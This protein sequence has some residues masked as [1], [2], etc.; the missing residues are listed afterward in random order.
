MQPRR[1]TVP[2]VKR[3]H[4]GMQTRRSTVRYREDLHYTLQQGGAQCSPAKEGC[5][6]DAP[7]ARTCIRLRYNRYFCR[8]DATFSLCHRRPQRQQQHVPTTRCTH[9]HKKSLPSTAS[10]S[11][12]KNAHL[13]FSLISMSCA[14]SKN[15]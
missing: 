4:R 7:L 10:L 14:R 1:Y 8:C 11:E 3:M 2:C 12:R 9:V 13:C 15:E 6:R 5:T